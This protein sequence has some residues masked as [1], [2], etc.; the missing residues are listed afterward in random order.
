MNHT[1]GPWRR[2][3]NTIVVRN[4]DGSLV[5]NIVSMTQKD[6]RKLGHEAVDNMRL[7]AAAPEMFEALQIAKDYI[8]LNQL[9]HTRLDVY[10]AVTEA[11]N[12]AEKG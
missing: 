6:Y 3:V 12:L 7:M 11:I 10:K 4:K 5:R 2:E 1:P 8:L 9:N